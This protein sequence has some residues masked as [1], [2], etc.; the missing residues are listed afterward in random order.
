MCT[1][2]RPTSPELLDDYF[3][4]SAPDIEFREEVYPGYQA[5]IFR[6]ASNDGVGDDPSFNAA[7]GSIY[8]NTA[9][10][11]GSNGAPGTLRYI[12][13]VGANSWMPMIDG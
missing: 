11:V 6:L 7:K 2:Y 1:N 10:T 9:G 5:P 3:G 4:A 12:N 13:L 8:V